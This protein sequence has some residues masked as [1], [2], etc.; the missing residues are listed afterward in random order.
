MPLSP[1]T[2]YSIAMETSL[3]KTLQE[4]LDRRKAKNPAYSLRAYARHL[5][6]SPAQ[7]SQILSG[8]RS[9]TLKSYRQIA[10][11][12]KFSPLES[13]QFLEEL[14]G[15]R[16]QVAITDLQVSDDQFRFISDWWHIG[17][18]TLAQIKKSRKDPAWI[19]KRLGISMWQAKESTQRLERMGLIDTGDQ[20]RRSSQTIRVGSAIPSQ[21]IQKSHTQIMQLASDKLPVVPMEER[22]YSS[23]TMAVDP[24]NIPKAKKLIQEFQNRLESLCEKGE[25]KE[26]YTFACQL[27]PMTEIV[28]QREDINRSPAMPS[29][30]E[31]V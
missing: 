31:S 28:S 3:T 11:I 9:I 5:G 8:K 22:H 26:V 21:A 1:K 18:L 19:A 24:V 23:V 10:E 16:T 30:N 4:E 6:L 27:F 12:L 15:P 20:L 2:A 25:T 17:I 7:L 29:K 13:L 14:G